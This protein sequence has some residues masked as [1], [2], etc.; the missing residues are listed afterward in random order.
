MNSLICLSK[1]P[2]TLRSRVAVVGPFF[3]S[4]ASDVSKIIKLKVELP[5]Y[6]VYS[7]HWGPLQD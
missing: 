4:I 5:W 7:R 6:T 1:L 3:N 2:S